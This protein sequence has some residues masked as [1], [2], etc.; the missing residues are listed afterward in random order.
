MEA[1]GGMSAPSPSLLPQ[2]APQEREPAGNAL[3]LRSRSAEQTRRLGALLGGV[4]AAGDVVLLS[5][6]LGAGKTAFTQGIA[7]GLGV[8]GA[9]NSPTF[10]LL[11]EYEG[12]LPLYHFDLYRIEDPDEVLALGFAEYF[13]GAGVSVIEW[14]ERGEVAD[15]TNDA[16]SPWPENWLRI[17]LRA[18]GRHSRELT[19]TA[20]GARGSDLLAAFTRATRQAAPRNA[21]ADAP[22]DA[23]S[24][25]ASEKDMPPC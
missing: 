6:A 22:A 8:R 5:G 9:V 21:T 17:T 10:T 1:A 23:A 11:K 24:E 15:D 20:H 16:P 19:I 3:I 12:R 2:P 25:I 4:L 13:A 14:A 18:T 7:V